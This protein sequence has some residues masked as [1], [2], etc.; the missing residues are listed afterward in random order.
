MSSKRRI[1]LILIFI[2]IVLLMGIGTYFF[3]TANII[4]NVEDD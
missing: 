1:A 4:G 3:F 2:S